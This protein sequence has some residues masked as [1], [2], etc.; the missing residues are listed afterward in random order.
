MSRAGA[1]FLLLVAAT[2]CAE[3]TI[4]VDDA[5]ARPTS[6]G[7]TAAYLSIHNGTGQAD[8]LTGAR[9]ACCAT[10]EIHQTLMRGDRMSMAPAGEGLVV[11]PGATVALKPGG[12]HLM[13]FEPHEPLRDGMR[14]ELVLEFESGGE[15]PVEVEVRR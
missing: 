14:F 15:I 11:E 5:W 3:G 1:W 9:S 13:L 6:L 4:R 10:I 2:A 7:P 8:R 12:H